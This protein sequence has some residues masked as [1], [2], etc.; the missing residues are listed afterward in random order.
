MMTEYEKTAMDFLKK[1]VE[2]SKTEGLEDAAVGLQAADL[3]L[4]HENNRVYAEQI[5]ATGRR[6]GDEGF[7]V[8]DTKSEDAD[9]TGL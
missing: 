3:I 8:D 1:L 5:L 4:K 6:L 7:S 9:G 2:S